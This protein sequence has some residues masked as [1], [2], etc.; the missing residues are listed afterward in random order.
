[1]DR[2]RTSLVA[3]PSGPDEHNTLMLEL[4]SSAERASGYRSIT[5]NGGLVTFTEVST[6]PTSLISPVA[7]R[8]V[9]PAVLLGSLMYTETELWSQY[10]PE[11]LNM[12]HQ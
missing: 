7:G 4:F 8:D 9:E 2:F 6:I 12:A 3:L 5:L 10:F 11:Q 1:M